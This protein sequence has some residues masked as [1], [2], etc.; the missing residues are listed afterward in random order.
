[1]FYRLKKHKSTALGPALYYS[2]LV[3]S[4]SKGSQVLLCTDGQANK[5]LG[6][7]D[8]K[9]ALKQSRSFYNEIT[10][11]AVANGFV[12]DYNLILKCL[13]LSLLIKFFKE[14]QSPL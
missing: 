12:L 11:L 6:A 14:Y 1:M 8:K 9:S 7:L 4:R 3:A 5:G 10:N 2:V 13:I